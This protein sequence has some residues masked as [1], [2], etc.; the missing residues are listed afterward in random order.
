MDLLPEAVEIAQL[1]LWIRS[2][3]PGQTLATLSANVVH[4]NSLV[5]D[6][7]VDPAAF[8]W[9]ERFPAVFDRPGYQGRGGGFD[10]V[11][12]NPPWERIKLQEREFFALPAPEIATASN[13]AARRRLVDALE[14]ADP[15][16]FARYQQAK[17]D[18]DRLLTYCRRS[19]DYPLCGRGDIEHLRRIRRAGQQ[20]RRAA[21][22]VGISVPSGIATDNTTKE[23]FASIA[24]TN[25]LVRLFDFENR[26][27]KLFPEV[28]GRFKFCILN[29]GGAE[30]DEATA[31]FVFFAHSVEET[32]DPARRIELTG[33]D[34][35]LLEPQHPHLPDLPYPPRRGDHQG[36]LPPRA[37]LDRPEPRR[38]H[39]QSVGRFLQDVCSIK[40]TTRSYS[41]RRPSY[42]TRG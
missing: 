39:W 13:A 19:G 21:G 36:D 26:T 3:T 2:A 30:T 22:R 10:C 35:R 11:I 29:Y 41:A 28:D 6:P 8:D 7:E 20:D 27:K 14:S 4:G 25:R 18:A 16:L 32:D 9:R 33:D 15:G 12:G 42:A 23:F 17:A 1:A 31:E 37:D 34:I 5:D 24:E 38:A 40:R